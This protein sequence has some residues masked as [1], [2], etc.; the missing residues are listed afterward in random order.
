M[1]EGAF[2]QQEIV[3]LIRD[4]THEV[5]RSYK[6]LS[7]SLGINLSDLL[8]IRFVRAEQGQA[9]PTA[10]G[11]QLGMTSGAT[12]ILINRLEGQGLLQRVQHPTDR[13]GTLLEIGPAAAGSALLN[14]ENAVERLRK[15][16]LDQYSEAELAVILRFLSDVVAGM[17]RG[18]DRIEAESA[19]R[20]NPAPKSE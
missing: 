6:A 14:S 19:G 5:S 12:A 20:P 16:L 2:M 3:S 1:M 11:R 7:A 10:L 8:A 17:R 18:N 9:T 13:R 15:H 4:L